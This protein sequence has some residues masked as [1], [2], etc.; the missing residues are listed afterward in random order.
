MAAMV[1]GTLV[2]AY[3]STDGF[4][5]SDIYDESTWRGWNY[6]LKQGERSLT[7]P[8]LTAGAR[9]DLNVVWC[10]YQVENG[11]WWQS[12]YQGGSAY[13]W[14]GSGGGS[15]ENSHGAKAC[16]TYDGR[17]HLVHRRDDGYYL[18]RTIAGG[19]GWEIPAQLMAVSNHTAA[20][21]V[22]ITHD[23]ALHMYYMR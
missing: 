11:N 16:A 8:G 20:P 23:N 1:D 15:T 10:A 5:Y 4:L 2:C 3:R 17:L 13:H 6:P 12:Y 7:G 22:L 19:I 14:P 18:Q 21:P 9:E